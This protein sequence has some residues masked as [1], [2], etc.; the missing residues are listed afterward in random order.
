MTTST[1]AFRPIT[2]AEYDSRLEGLVYPHRAST[3][4]DDYA[5]LLP[6]RELW[7]GSRWAYAP[8]GE[9]L[10][11]LTLRQ[12]RIHK[13][14][15]LWAEG[16][17][18]WLAGDPSA[19]QEQALVDALGPFVR[20]TDHSQAFIRLAVLHHEDV[21]GIV[22]TCQQLYAHDSTVVID[23]TG[24]EAAL[25]SRMKKRGRRD[26]NKGLRESQI[27][28]AEETMISREDFED[29]IG[30]MHET[31][32]RQGFH[33]HDADYYWTFL[34]HFRE[35]G[36]ARLWVG[37]LDGRPV[38]WGLA[39][40]RGDFATWEVAASAPESRRQ[41]G[42]D[43]TLYRALLDMQASGITLVD[44]AAIGSDYNPKLMPLNEF[45]TK[46]TEGTIRVAAPMEIVLKPARYRALNWLAARRSGGDEG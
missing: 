33:D 16:S 29:V 23:T 40:I 8:A 5:A 18:V 25:R 21:T 4:W 6:E 34:T 24:D 20:A 2:D 36:Q 38:N 7:R 45:K 30:V 19:E 44:L 43:L 35:R 14:A 32:G 22:P 1:P 15:F 39:I 31:A 46:W 37:R 11:V 3:A 28:V 17:P 27:V 13:M 9:V 26:V 41:H 12:F 10:A 42:P